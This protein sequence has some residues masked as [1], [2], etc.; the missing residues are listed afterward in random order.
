MSDKTAGSI[1]IV[2]GASPFRVY[3]KAAMARLVSFAG[4]VDV[5]I[6]AH[7][8]IDKPISVTLHSPGVYYILGP[9][10]YQKQEGLE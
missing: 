7:R 5:P 9:Y 8:V 10:D 2:N 3:I 4:S 1:R 6:K